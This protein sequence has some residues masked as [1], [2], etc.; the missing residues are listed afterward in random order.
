MKV[1]DKVRRA[2]LEPFEVDLLI[3]K[4]RKADGVI[5]RILPD[6]EATYRRN[7]P[8]CYEVLWTWPDG[9]TCLAHYNERQIEVING[10]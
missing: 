6:A 7:L 3:T 2:D 4:L 10:I 9:E 8:L 1:G 5:K